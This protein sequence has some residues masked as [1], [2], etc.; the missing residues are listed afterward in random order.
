MKELLRQ[1]LL[2]IFSTFQAISTRH[3]SIPKEMFS[4][5]DVDVIEGFLKAFVFE[6]VIRRNVIGFSITVE[7]S[8]VLSN[9]ATGVLLMRRMIKST[10]CTQI[11]QTVNTRLLLGSLTTDDSKHTQRT[12][13]RPHGQPKY[14]TTTSTIWISITFT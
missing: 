3:T 2:L 13:L 6:V 11:T 5:E 8:V 14:S 9:F 7:S 1:G 12:K 10:N 4:L